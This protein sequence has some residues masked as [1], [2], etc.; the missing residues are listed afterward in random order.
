MPAI[1]TTDMLAALDYALAEYDHH[2]MGQKWLKPVAVLIMDALVPT[3]RIPEGPTPFICMNGMKK[4]RWRKDVRGALRHLKPY[5]HECLVDLSVMQGAT[6]P[7]TTWLTAES[8]GY[9]HHWRPL[10]NNER[11]GKS[12]YMWDLYKLL[13]VRSPT[14][15]FFTLC[16]SRHH[17]ILARRTSQMVEKY[18]MDSGDADL[19]ALQFPTASMRDQPVRILHWAS[20]R[21]AEEPVRTDW[22]IG[23]VDARQERAPDAS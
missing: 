3:L 4:E 10:Y 12:D 11:W 8:E 22:V 14:M 13:Q 18:Q 21:H 6:D 19:W 9:Q 1:S 2:K 23:A 7:Y 15:L 16:P 17:D 20:G 5:D